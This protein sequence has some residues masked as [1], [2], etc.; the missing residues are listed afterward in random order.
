M[1]RIIFTLAIVATLLTSAFSQKVNLESAITYYRNGD[2]L[3]MKDAKT[4]IDKAAANEETSVK[5]KTWYY[6]GL[7]YNKIEAEDKIKNLDSNAAEKALESFLKC[8]SIDKK[9]EFSKDILDVYEDNTSCLLTYTTFRAFNYALG[10]L[11]KGDYLGTLKIYDNI[12]QVYKYDSRGEL[13]TN[14]LSRK[15]LWELTA[16]IN[17]R[18]GNNSRSKELFNILIDSGYNE[19]NVFTSLYNLYINDKDTANALIVLEK[20]ERIFT[21]DPIFSEIEIQLYLNSGNNNL[22]I[23]KVS[24]KIEKSPDNGKY[25][26]YRGLI[27]ED[28]R[29][30]MAAKKVPAS[31]IDSMNKLIEPDYKKAIELNENDTFSQYNLGAF[32]FNQVIP[33][34]SK[35][36][37][38]DDKK[39]D[40]KTKLAQLEN[41]KKELL[42]KARPHL[43]K[44][45]ELKDSDRQI[46]EALQHLYEQLKMP[47][48]AKE[49]EAKAKALKK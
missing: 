21:E 26:Y 35:I 19:R 22:F 39:P 40:Y 49:M 17:I 16:Y 14:N 11:N 25:Y 30:D 45:Y 15:K 24:K 13:K 38:L 4:Y 44:A 1:K 37:K 34:I 3:S 6:R 5:P 29:N 9:E 33:I 42:D 41:T 20:A 46:V 31:S 28:I 12:L 8:L 32:Y 27:Y 7:I 48:K 18:L 43:E 23:S 47:E 10:K 36:G 2:E